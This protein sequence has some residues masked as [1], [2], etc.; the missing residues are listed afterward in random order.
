MLEIKRIRITDDGSLKP[1]KVV[2]AETGK[3]P[4]WFELDYHVDMESIPSTTI[5]V[6]YTELNVETDV[7]FITICPN[8]RCEM[9]GDKVLDATSLGETTRRPMLM[10]AE[11]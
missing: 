10:R 1:P 7:R 4:P 8:C 9:D 3:T 2:D 5:K 11:D 6:Y